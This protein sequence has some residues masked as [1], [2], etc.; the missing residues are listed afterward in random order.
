MKSE[1]RNVL[2]AVGAAVLLGAVVLAFLPVSVTEAG[3]AADCG[4]PVSQSALVDL[5]PS[6]VPALESRSLLA[7]VVA[8]IGVGLLV[9]AGYFSYRASAADGAA[10]Q[11]SAA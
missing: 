7:W 10:G 2:Y 6:C 1:M 4:G 8:A 3:L 5:Y 9:T 11:E